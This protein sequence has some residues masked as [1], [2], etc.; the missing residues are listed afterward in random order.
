VDDVPIANSLGSAVVSRRPPFSSEFKG[1][2]SA[3]YEFPLAGGTM[4]LQADAQHT[5]DFYFSLTNFAATK[6]DAYTL[7]NARIGW[8]SPEERWQVAAF[9]RN[10]SDERYRT[11]GFEASDFGGWTQVGYGE[12]RWWGVTVEYRL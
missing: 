2:F 11:V 4:D 1:L 5:G 10:L 7:F 8:S 12:P 3:R 9:G 6:V